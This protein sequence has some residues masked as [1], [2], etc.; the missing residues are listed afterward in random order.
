MLELGV[1]VVVA[2]KASAM[3]CSPG[4]TDH[5]LSMAHGRNILVVVVVVVAADIAAAVAACKHPA[6]TD[7]Q[8]PVTGRERIQRAAGAGIA[9]V[10]GPNS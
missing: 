1:G 4:S 6:C 2:G 10:V 5:S 3:V 8:P 9:T 7:C